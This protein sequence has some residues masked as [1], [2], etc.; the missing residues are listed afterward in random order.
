MT[1][2]KKFP[3]RIRTQKLIYRYLYS[4][5][6]KSPV[7]LSFL[8]FVIFFIILYCPVQSV[9]QKTG[10]HACVLIVRYEIF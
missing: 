10:N 9:D 8:I 5:E 4:K 7:C 1:S 6:K 2:L 3:T